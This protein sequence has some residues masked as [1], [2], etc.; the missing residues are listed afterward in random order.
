MIILWAIYCGANDWEVILV[1][2]VELCGGFCEWLTKESR[3]RLSGKYVN[4]LI[5]NL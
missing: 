4:M 5:V 2:D 3:E 1:D